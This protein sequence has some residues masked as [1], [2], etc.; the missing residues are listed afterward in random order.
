M[1]I[2]LRAWLWLIPIMNNEWRR[3]VV[4]PHL[5][6]T[7]WA[8]DCIEDFRDDGWITVIDS[9]YLVS[10]IFLSGGKVVWIS[11]S[12]IF[13]LISAS[14]RN[15]IS[16][17][18]RILKHYIFGGR[19]ETIFISLNLSLHLPNNTMDGALRVILT[20]LVSDRHVEWHDTLIA[21]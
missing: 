3:S 20:E 9:V 2:I 13:F 12:N 11:C 15:F 19:Q 21:L 17:R 6:A 8:I 5:L 14:K 1:I 18:K 4:I 7:Q 16:N 10:T